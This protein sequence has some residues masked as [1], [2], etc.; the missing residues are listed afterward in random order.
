MAAVE[1]DA[2]LALE[3]AQRL[4]ICQFWIVADDESGVGPDANERGRL[5]SHESGPAASAN[6]WN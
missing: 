5:D 2:N 1:L 3:L 4:A 6:S